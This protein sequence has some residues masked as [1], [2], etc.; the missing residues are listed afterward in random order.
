MNKRGFVLT[1]RDGDYSHYGLVFCG[2]AFFCGS[3]AGA[4]AAGFVN[5]ETK[6]SEYLTAFLSFFMTGTSVKQG[7][8]LRRRGCVQV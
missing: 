8:F 5:D 1:L 6:L 3:I 4:V 2:V 7:F